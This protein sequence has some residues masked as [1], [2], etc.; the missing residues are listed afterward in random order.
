MIGTIF[1]GYKIVSFIA[2]GGMATIYEAQHPTLTRRRVV[3]KFL[4]PQ[5]LANEQ[6]KQR[7]INEAQTM[8][9]LEHPKIVAVFELFDEDGKIGIVMELLKGV[10]LSKYIKAN[11]PLPYNMAVK[12][13]IDVLAAFEY[14]HSNGIVHRDIKPSN[15]FM[16]MDGTIKILDFGI[17]KILDEQQEFTK[18]G[19]QLGTPSYM[20][21][22]QV[23]ESKNI[24]S[25]S[26]IYS[27]GVTLYYLLTG[28]S[29]YATTTNSSYDLMNKIVNEPLPDL[30][31]IQ[32]PMRSVIIKATQKNSAL[33]FQNCR[34]FSN[35]IQGSGFQPNPQPRPFPNPDNKDLPGRSAAQVLGIIGLVF[36]ILFMPLGILVS[37]AGLIVAE[38]A[39]KKY[40]ETPQEY[41]PKDLKDL[42]VSTNLS[43]IGVVI[44]VLWIVFFV[45]LLIVSNM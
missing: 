42:K 17:A 31:R 13:Y 10:D 34:E 7:F 29:P 23:K 39:K 30:Y 26:D 37:I 19:S 5:L 3:I 43:I 24:D 32:E 38:Q 44:S 41:S 2:E 35:A 33:R 25:R 40:N 21:P 20:S 27:L 12:I 6:I 14:A 18:T 8:S 36:S 11:G 28:I 16:L 9:L 4:K 15:I 45:F 22:E 1:H